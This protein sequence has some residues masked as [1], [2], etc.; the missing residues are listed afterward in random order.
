M[1]L[2]FFDE[3]TCERVLYITYGNRILTK[4][5]FFHFITIIFNEFFIRIYNINYFKLNYSEFSASW[6][7]YKMLPF[8]L[9]L[10]KSIK[11]ITF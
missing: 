4:V 8:T 11:I 1:C 6:S 3:A 5:F 9:L 10:K 2:Y 7:V